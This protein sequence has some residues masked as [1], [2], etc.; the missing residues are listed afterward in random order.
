M[1]TMIHKSGKDPVMPGNYRPICLLPTLAKIAEKIIKKRLEEK[2]E[3]LELIQPEQFGFRRGLSTDLQLVR[4]VELILKGRN[5]GRST[6]AVFLDL[7][8]AFDRVWHDGL[9]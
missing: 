1:V 6:G 9:L 3:R 7:A 8:S 2:M 5:I 4:V